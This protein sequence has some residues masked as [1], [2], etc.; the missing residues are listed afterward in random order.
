[1]AEE[2]IGMTSSGRLENCTI[3]ANQKCS[4]HPDHL[5][6]VRLSMKPFLAPVDLDDDLEEVGV[7]LS[8][9]NQQTPSIQDMVEEMNNLANKMVKGW[10][11]TIEKVTS[12]HNE[13]TK[14][15]AELRN[16]SVEEYEMWLANLDTAQEHGLWLNAAS[17]EDDYITKAKWVSPNEEV[18][19][20]ETSNVGGSY[21]TKFTSYIGNSKQKTFEVGQPFKI[22]DAN[23]VKTFIE[24]N[25]L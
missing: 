9:Y 22:S 15:L 20:I 10:E 21:N 12:I 14:K 8:S 13:T 2:R 24:D 6:G 11:D 7:S 18:V 25:L 1:M 4:R 23:H 5:D 16:M 3:P 19:E 17:D